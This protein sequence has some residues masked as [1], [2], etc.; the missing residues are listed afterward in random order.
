M[1]NIEK[2]RAT[3]DF[4]V[5][6]D[7]SQMSES[8]QAPELPEHLQKI[9]TPIIWDQWQWMDHFADLD[10]E[11]DNEFSCGTTRCCFAGWGAL[12][13]GWEPA[14][15]NCVIRVDPNTSFTR[16]E[17]VRDVAAEIFEL[18][19]WEADQIFAP[20]NLLE[21]IDNWIK[22]FAG[23]GPNPEEEGWSC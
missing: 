10:P 4:I 13:E 21:D 1:A 12:L 9:N 19:N 18:T 22:Y 3:Y 16:T 11:A 6:L 8:A 7:K 15:D 17:M 5:A 14:R 23:E 2:L 20:G